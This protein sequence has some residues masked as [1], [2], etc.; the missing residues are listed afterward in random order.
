MDIDK[1]TIYQN[2]RNE[3]MDLVKRQDTYLLASYTLCI[4]VWAFALEAKNA[5]VALLP[6]FILLPLSMR[7]SDFRHGMVFLSSFMAVFLEESSYN[8]WEY[9]REE[10]YKQAKEIRSLKQRPTECKD[11]FKK[12]SIVL[13]FVSKATFTL[14]TLISIIMF[15]GL[16]T[17]NF[18]SL[19]NIVINSI[20]LII[21]AI[22]LFT[23]IYVAIKYRD[24][25][26]MKKSLLADWNFVYNKLSEDCLSKQSGETNE[27]L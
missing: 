20:M 5:W 24:T 21:Q 23:Q 8:G 13:S 18:S 27:K 19:S 3:M 25:T 15:W 22:I 12:K 4:T 9:V 6:A 11:L 17:F 16:K 26:I 2:L 1:K 14:L 7:F 10:Y